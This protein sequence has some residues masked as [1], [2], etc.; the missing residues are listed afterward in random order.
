MSRSLKSSRAFPALFDLEEQQPA[1]RRNAQGFHRR[2]F[3]SAVFGGVHEQPILSIGSIS[4]VNARL[5]LV[6]ETL[7]EKYGSGPLRES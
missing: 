4:H 1:V 7:A 6:C 2:V 5:L 3:S